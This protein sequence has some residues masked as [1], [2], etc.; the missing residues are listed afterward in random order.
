MSIG[1]MLVALGYFG[2]VQRMLDVQ[3]TSVEFP[4]HMALALDEA[5]V[6][7]P[8]RTERLFDAKGRSVESTLT[9][10]SDLFVDK[11]SVLRHVERCLDTHRCAVQM[12]RS[13]LWYVA[14]TVHL[15]IVLLLLI[16]EVRLQ[17]Q[18]GTAHV[19]LEALSMKECEVLERT[20]HVDLVHG[21]PTS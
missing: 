20:Y 10:S 13:S 14:F 2:G 11:L 4:R 16:V 21:L 19:A 6:V 18:S 7:G 17:S 3:S 5:L 15:P 1:P 9:R 12:T 8:R